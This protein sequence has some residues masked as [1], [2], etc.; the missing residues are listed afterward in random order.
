[1]YIFNVSNPITLILMLAMTLILI[2][3][4]KETKKGYLTAISL[5]V[6][7]ILL[8]WHV[9]QL[10]TI[11]PEF[12]EVKSILTSCLIIDFVMILL[13]FLSYIWV[14][15]LESRTGK[16][17]KTFDAGLDWFWGKSN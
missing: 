6:F 15:E 9:G 4:G 14:D 1:M 12:E 7:L 3:L 17:K 2:F 11:T 8:I 10:V 13:S 16:K 5:L